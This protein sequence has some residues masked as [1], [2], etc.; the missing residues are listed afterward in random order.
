MIHEQ[1]DDFDKGDGMPEGITGESATAK[2][3]LCWRPNCNNYHSGSHEIDG[4]TYA[5]GLCER[6]CE[7]AVRAMQIQEAR[8]IERVRAY[9]EA[10]KDEIAGGYLELKADFETMRFNVALD[11][12]HQAWYPAGQRAMLEW[13]GRARRQLGKNQDVTKKGSRRANSQ[14]RGTKP[15]R[16][17]GGGF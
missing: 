7:A 4:V 16:G 11:P 6:H 3:Y 12:R 10:T 15:Y 1:S 13:E 14:I 5:S 8:Y 17:R 2:R 9:W